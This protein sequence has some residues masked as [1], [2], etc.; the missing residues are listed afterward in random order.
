MLRAF[1]APLDR[2]LPGPLL[3][4]PF[5]IP[6][7]DRELTRAFQHPDP[8]TLAPMFASLPGGV[9][10]ARVAI[11]AAYDTTAHTLAFALWELAGRP[12]LNDADQV[13]SVVQETLR[14]YPAGWIGSRVA[15]RATE[16]DGIPIPAGRMVLYSPYLTH[17]D[18]QLWNDPLA[19]RPER[20]TEPLPAWGYLPFAAGE[21]TCLGAALATL[22]LRSVLAGFGG[23]QLERISQDV[24]PKGIITLTPGAPIVL[25]RRTRRHRST[26]CTTSNP[27]TTEPA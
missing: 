18:P 16:F 9:Q 26:V 10:E 13:E 17:R 6:A 20:F 22:M 3:P 5:R 24:R 11:A 1:L 12:D 25:R 27:S 21:R 14:L 15:T 7:M 2:G 8:T 4:R 23:A 19:F